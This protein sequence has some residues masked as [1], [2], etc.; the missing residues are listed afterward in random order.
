MLLR[1]KDNGIGLPE[2]FAYEQ[3]NSLGIQLV[4]SLVEQLDAELEIKGKKG[5]EFIIRFEKQD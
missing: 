3:S 2:D 1:V 5:T 4:Y